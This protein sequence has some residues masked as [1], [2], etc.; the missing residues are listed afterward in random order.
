MRALS[1]SGATCMACLN[2]LIA[3]GYFRVSRKDCPCRTSA[4]YRVL[5]MSSA[6]PELAAV[7][8]SD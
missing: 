8:S 1:A 4:A 6:E 2:A 5:A 3:S 7:A